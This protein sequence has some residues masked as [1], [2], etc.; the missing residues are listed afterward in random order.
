[1]ATTNTTIKAWCAR[2]NELDTEIAELEKKL[3]ALKGEKDDFKAKFVE[4]LGEKNQK[5]VD[6]YIAKTWTQTRHNVDTKAIIAD[7]DLYAKYGKPDTVV[8]YFSVTEA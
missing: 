2:V 7:A 8:Q 4:E 5:A 3:K 6:G 1:M